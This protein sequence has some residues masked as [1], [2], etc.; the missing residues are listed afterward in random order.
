MPRSSPRYESLLLPKKSNEMNNRKVFL[1]FAFMVLAVGVSSAQPNVLFVFADDIRAESIVEIEGDE[2]STPN[3]DRLARMGMSFTNAY[4]MG[5]LTAPVCLASR[6][7]MLTGRGVFQQEYRG[8]RIPDGMRT[9]PE[10]FSQLRCRRG[11]L[12]RQLS[13]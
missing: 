13:R 7:M 4:T 12:A 5:S 1:F 6:A 2:I 11:E 8:R 3:L 10:A 9:F